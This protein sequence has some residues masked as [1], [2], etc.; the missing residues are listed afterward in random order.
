M[1]KELVE[2][3]Y[4]EALLRAA[5]LLGDLHRDAPVR[6]IIISGFSMCGR[7]LHQ[8]CRIIG[9]PC[10]NPYSTAETATEHPAED[11]LILYPIRES[12]PS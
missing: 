2:K 11:Y 7:R 9:Q 1:T 4:M 3:N 8:R 12:M 10:L 6:E 5:L